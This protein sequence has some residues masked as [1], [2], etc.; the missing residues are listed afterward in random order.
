MSH[1]EKKIKRRVKKIKFEYMSVQYLQTVAK[2]LIEP[3]NLVV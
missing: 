3:K 1:K 2:K